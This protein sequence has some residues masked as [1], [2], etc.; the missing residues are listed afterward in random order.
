MTTTKSFETDK[1]LYIALDKTISNSDSNS[2]IK[3][4]NDILIIKNGKIECPKDIY[5]IDC[6]DC[7]RYVNCSIMEIEQ[8]KK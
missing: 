3:D 1:V 5:R 2:N 4:Y 8:I 7:P 6:K